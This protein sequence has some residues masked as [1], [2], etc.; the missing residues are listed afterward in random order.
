G[1]WRTLGRQLALM[2]KQ[3]NV[4]IHF[5]ALAAGDVDE[6][7]S[8]IRGLKSIH[9]TIGCT[10]PGRWRR[11]V[12]DAEHAIELR[13]RV[14][15]VKGEWAEERAREVDPKAGFLAIVERIAGRVPHVSI[16]THDP[17]LARESIRRL[18]LAGTPC[19]I[20]VL[21]G[22]PMNEM[23]S[24][25]KSEGMPLRVYVP[26]GRLSPPYSRSHV[27]RNPRVVRWAVRDLFRRS[28]RT[29]GTPTAATVRP[30]LRGTRAKD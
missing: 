23:I 17:D 28:K 13:L 27:R 8:L 25:A 26:F 29:L 21:L 19:E 9:P 3:R 6:T 18:R 15:V 7:F 2:A 30:V 22:Y 20:E 24:L 12:Q 10:L 5:D 4:V 1:L 14:R 11:S 16:A